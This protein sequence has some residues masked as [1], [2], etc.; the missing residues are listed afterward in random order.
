MPIEG[1]TGGMFLSVYYFC[2]VFLNYRQ[3]TLHLAP[4]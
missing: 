2:F 1:K 3:S 4:L